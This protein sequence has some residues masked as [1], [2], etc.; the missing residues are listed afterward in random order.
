[1]VPNVGSSNDRLSHLQDIHADL[2]RKT[3]VLASLRKQ[4][5]RKEAALHA[6]VASRKQLSQMQLANADD[7]SHVQHRTAG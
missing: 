3:A 4:V 6:K 2:L 1:M 7:P 5:E